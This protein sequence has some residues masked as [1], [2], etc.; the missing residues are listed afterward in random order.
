MSKF[1]IVM[2]CHEDGESSYTDYVNMLFND[3]E[4]AEREMKK[5][6]EQEIEQL[7]EDAD[8]TYYSENNCVCVD[9]F[10]VTEYYVIEITNE[11]KEEG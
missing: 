2:T 9:G 11:Y 6:I 5:C 10:C 1:L 3:R 7:N 4:N 8:L